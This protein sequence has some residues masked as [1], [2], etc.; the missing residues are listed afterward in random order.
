MGTYHLI[1][2]FVGCHNVNINPVFLSFF[3]NG[4]EHIICFISL[5][6]N[7]GDPE[8]VNHFPYRPDLYKKVIRCFR[9]V[10]LVLFIYFMSLRRGGGIK[11]NGKI[12]GCF[13]PQHLEYHIGKTVDSVCGKSL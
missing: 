12:I 11:D 5:N 10:S 6:F 1:N 9:S 8:R 3:R 7:T 2:I 13:F 4:A